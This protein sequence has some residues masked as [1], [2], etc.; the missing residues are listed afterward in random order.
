MIVYNSNVTNNIMY[1]G[2]FEGTGNLSSNNI[3]NG[4]QFGT[5]DG[6]QSSVDMTTVFLGTG[7][8]DNFFKLKT[9]SPAIAA[10]YGSTQ[11]V[12]VDA[13]MYGGSTPYVLSGIPAIP[14]IY[15]FKNQPVGS[16]SDPIDVQVKVRSNN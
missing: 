10:G 16:N 13:G 2:T 6:N 7:S 4:T 9:G 5:T 15:Y 8:Y 1:R 11:Q 12:P 3:S 14:S